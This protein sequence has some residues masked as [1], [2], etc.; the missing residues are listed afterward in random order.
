ML[1][2]GPMYYVRPF[3][4][5]ISVCRFL[6]IGTFSLALSVCFEITFITLLC[7]VGVKFCTRDCRLF[8]LPDPIVQS[9]LASHQKMFK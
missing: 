6:K 5:V 9:S 2:I 3:N 4:S 1:Y 8:F 7:V